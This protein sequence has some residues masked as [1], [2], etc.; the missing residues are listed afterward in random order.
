MKY[1]KLIFII[2]LLFAFKVAA[3]NTNSDI[4]SVWIFSGHP[5]MD[6]KQETF[7]S[8]IMSIQKT[9]IEDY[10]LNTKEIHLYINK[11]GNSS[12]ACTK[13]NVL[14]A[15]NKINQ[16]I[17][18]GE[19]CLVIFLGHA[20]STAKDIHY[21]LPG[22]DIS[23]KELSKN[24]NPVKGQG[25][26]GII[27]AVES[28]ERAVKMLA[29]KNL[30]VLAS[31][32]TEDRDNEPVLNEIF[33]KLLNKNLVD[34]NK[35]GNVSFFELHRLAKKEVKKWYQDRGLIQLEKIILDGDGNGVGTSAPS[36]TDA[37]KAKKIILKY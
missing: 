15:F 28:G 5:G 34:E 19:N 27:W 25:S 33:E 36:P 6:E 30:V 1:Y 35:D 16:L 8:K 18:Q 7:K 4:S 31:A 12:L 22:R 29:N 23:M 2:W 32:E 20:N 13:E 24:I 37:K 3:N 11:G 17:K 14:I 21:N 10:N 9:L 26:L